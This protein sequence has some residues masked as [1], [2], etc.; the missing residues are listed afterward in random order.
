[1]EGLFTRSSSS[2]GKLSEH[3]WDA[4]AERC[5]VMSDLFEGEAHGNVALIKDVP[6]KAW[7][8]MQV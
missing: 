2:H 4:F 7:S 6:F 8:L 1:M 5:Q 3:L